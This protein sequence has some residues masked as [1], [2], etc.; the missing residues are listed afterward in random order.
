MWNYLAPD[1]ISFR[2]LTVVFVFR[3]FQPFFRLFFSHVKFIREGE[4]CIQ[5][6]CSIQCADKQ[7]QK[8]HFIPKGTSHKFVF[9][10]LNQFAYNPISR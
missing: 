3:Y 4:H 7:R 10:F 5:I 1:A 2:A 8:E 6:Q 9:V